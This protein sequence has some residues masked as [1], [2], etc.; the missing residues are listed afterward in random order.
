MTSLNGNLASAWQRFKATG[1]DSARNALVEH[2]WPAVLEHARCARKHEPTLDAED[3]SQE[4]YPAL[5][6]AMDRFR[7]EEGVKFE[8]FIY[9]LIKGGMCQAQYRWGFG[10]A[11]P[12]RTPGPGCHILL[13]CDMEF[14]PEK[15]RR[16][17][18]M[19]W[20]VEP[21]EQLDPCN[22]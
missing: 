8:T 22:E 13:E 7:P 19:G 4:V 15:G 11:N 6:R 2:Y 17:R 3:L 5:V 9:R 16:V 14:T 1:C 18:G 21:P 20:A 10:P 12:H